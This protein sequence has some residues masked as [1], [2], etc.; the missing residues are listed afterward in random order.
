MLDFPF[1]LCVVVRDV[2]GCET[3]YTQREHSMTNR[4][5]RRINNTGISIMDV[6]CIIPH[7]FVTLPVG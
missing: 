5:D 7:V 3:L 2:L 4:T 1:S 6:Y